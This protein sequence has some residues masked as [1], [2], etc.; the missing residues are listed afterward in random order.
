MLVRT[1]S[2]HACLRKTRKTWVAA[3]IE[4]KDRSEET[5]LFEHLQI[6]NILTSQPDWIFERLSKWW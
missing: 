5:T 6:G 3:D 2:A 4:E 1:A